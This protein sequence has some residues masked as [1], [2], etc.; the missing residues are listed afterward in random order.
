MVVFGK[1]LKIQNLAFNIRN[2]WYLNSESERG[3]VCAMKATVNDVTELNVF[4]YAHELTL[5]AL[6]LRQRKR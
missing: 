4:K 3:R 1:Q 2:N 5:E 6:R